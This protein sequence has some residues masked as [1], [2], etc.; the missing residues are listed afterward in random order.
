[1]QCYFHNSQVV[2][3]RTYEIA[4]GDTAIKDTQGLIKFAEPILFNKYGEKQI[5]SE[6]P[7]VISFKKGTW[8]MHGS[9]PEGMLGGTFSI[10]IRAKDGK[11]IDLVHFK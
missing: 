5:L 8:Y 10:S 4:R 1:M 2:Q 6:K 3:P 9:L 7:Y 11:V